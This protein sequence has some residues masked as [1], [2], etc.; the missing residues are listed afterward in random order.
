M[1]VT[2]C[3]SY[4]S[5]PLAGSATHEM[6]PPVPCCASSANMESILLRRLAEEGFT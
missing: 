6:W 1:C 3:Y 2:L 4:I 5:R